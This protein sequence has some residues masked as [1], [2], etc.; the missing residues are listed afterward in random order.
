[1]IEPEALQELADSIRE[2][3]L[4]QAPLARRD[5]IRGRFQLAFG[6]RRV[7]AIRLLHQQGAWDAHVEIDIAELT[8]KQMVVMGLTENERRKELSQIEIARAYKRTIADTGITA[9]ELANQVGIDRSTLSNYL[10]VLELPDFVLEHVESGALGIAVAM[11][12]LALQNADHAHDDVLENVVNG[13]VK[14]IPWASQQQPPD[15][16]KGNVRTMIADRVAHAETE[17]RPL[18][19]SSGYAT[20]PAGREANFDFEAFAAERPHLVHTIPAGSG[21]QPN[22]SRNWTCD[23][24]GWRREQTKATRE[25]N[26]AAAESGHKPSGNTPKPVSRDKKFEQLLA[27]D[28]VWQG[29]IA[30]RE[31]PGPNRPLT[32]AERE[33]LGSRA[34]L[35]DISWDTGFWKLL[36]LA[37]PDDMYGWH[38]TSGGKVPPW[39]PDLDE[40]RNCSIGATWAKSRGVYMQ[41]SEGA[42]VCFNKAHYQEKMAAGEAAY[43]E[44]VEAEKLEI[45]RQDSRVM[46]GMV[47]QLHP[48]TDD[49]CKT[50]ATPGPAAQP[51]L[52]WLHPLGDYHEAWSYES[53]AVARVRE[54]AEG[55]IDEEQ[56]S[57]YRNART[58]VDLAALDKVAPDDLRELVA[59]LLTHHLRQAGKID[60]VSQE[61][62]VPLKQGEGVPSHAA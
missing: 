40:C 32:D 38:R 37:E 14:P 48:L 2:I 50:M 35:R 18:S 16:R 61:S 27:D 39:F 56:Y 25:A 12:L 49:A 46:R 28:P 59:A 26:Q 36:K 57:Y 47:R 30:Q 52:E 13:I 31:K 21:N 10:R 7:A 43:R 60:T 34:E 55:Q 3:G 11:E 19:P 6:H 53:G 5:T 51:V 20:G 24:K 4:L 1:M 33:A 58:V 22:A 29:M 62:P 44:K 9:Q 42:L 8:D 15:W 23:V 17:F 41:L 45:Q 54:L